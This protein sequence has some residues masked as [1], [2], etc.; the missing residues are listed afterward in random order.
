MPISDWR[1]RGNV[2]S[3]KAFEDFHKQ[4]P[5]LAEGLRWW[6]SYLSL[7]RREQV[8]MQPKSPECSTRHLYLQWY[9]LLKM[10]PFRSMLCCGQCLENFCALVITSVG[11]NV[12][13]KSKVFAA[14]VGRKTRWDYLLCWVQE[15]QFWSTERVRRGPAYLRKNKIAVHNLHT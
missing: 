8:R 7:R 14:C 15:I 9:V 3:A 13:N 10:L 6:K 11:F 4:N 1:M 5:Q 12:N 2:E